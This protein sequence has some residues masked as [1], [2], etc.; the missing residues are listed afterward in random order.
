M[1][2]KAAKKWLSLEGS[3]S[4]KIYSSSIKNPYAHFQYVSNMS[5]K[6]EKHPLKTVREVDYT[7][8]IPYNAQTPY[9]T[10]QKMPKMTKFERL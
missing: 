5:V 2:K 7:N 8:P 10:M 4:V 3:N 9:P 1:W 6:F